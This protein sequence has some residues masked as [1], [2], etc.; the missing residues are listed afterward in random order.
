MG[1][2]GDRKA[3]TIPQRTMTEMKFGAYSRSCMLR[4]ARRPVTRESTNAMMTGGRK[5]HSRPNTLSFRVL[6][7]SLGNSGEVRK[8]VKL[9][10]PMNLLPRIPSRLLYF[11]NAMIKPPI[12]KYLNTSV[13]RNAGSMKITYSCQLFLT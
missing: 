4:L 2:T 10:S 8:R 6:P 11:W 3:M 12:G 1:P 13:S 5:P 7:I 9:S